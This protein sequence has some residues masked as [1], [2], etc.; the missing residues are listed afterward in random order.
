METNFLIFRKSFLSRVLNDNWKDISISVF[1]IILD[2]FL[3]IDPPLTNI[4]LAIIIMT[5]V[6]VGINLIYQLFQTAR[7]EKEYQAIVRDVTKGVEGFLFSIQVIAFQ[8]TPTLRH[9]L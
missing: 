3:Y 5:I 1:T 6:V 9:F 7:R 8:I 2:G 4:K